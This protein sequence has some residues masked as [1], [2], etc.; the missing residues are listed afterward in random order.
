MEM[1][2]NVGEILSAAPDVKVSESAGDS[3]ANISDA[4]T[5]E[6]HR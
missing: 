5:R 6:T 4:G 3:K 1:T 2:R